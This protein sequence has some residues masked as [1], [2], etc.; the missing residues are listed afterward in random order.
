MAAERCHSYSRTMSTLHIEHAITDYATWRDAFD[1]FADVRLASGVVGTR[2]ARPVDDEHFIVVDLDFDSADAAAAFRT[3]L[4]LN[5]WSSPQNS[6][7]LAGEPRAAVL[8]S[9]T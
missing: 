5:V 1:G 6:P 4:R 2:V 8:N 3:F 7:G 9:V